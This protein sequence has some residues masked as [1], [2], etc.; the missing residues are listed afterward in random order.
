MTLV[1]DRKLEGRC[2]VCQLIRHS[3][4]QGEMLEAWIL[5][6]D[7]STAQIAD[8]FNNQFNGVKFGGWTYKELDTKKI[9]THR[10]KHIP[11][12]HEIYS[13]A[14]EKGLT[15]NLSLEKSVMDNLTLIDALKQSGIM[16]VLSGDIDVNS[17]KD[18]MDIL[19]RE[20][21][22]LG[23]EKVEISIGSGSGIMMPPELMTAIVE[24]MTR[25]VPQDKV[26]EFRKALDE[27][28]KPKFM[29]YAN[30]YTDHK[31]LERENKSNGPKVVEAEVVGESDGGSS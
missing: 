16:K 6:G 5:S 19:D 7:K 22:L 29:E 25:F 11:Q 28:V 31:A 8:Y 17:L 27:E 20:Y 2:H 21:K 18:L 9:R 30:K 26:I 4:E 10:S 15:G 14:R 24:V 1:Y 12:K 3:P 23:G 13:R